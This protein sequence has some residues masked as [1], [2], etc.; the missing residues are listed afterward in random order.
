MVNV[1]T[2]LHQMKQLIYDKH[3][4]RR[5]SVPGEG[6]YGDRETCMEWSA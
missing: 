3:Q 2:R 6:T 4:R 1:D 5:C